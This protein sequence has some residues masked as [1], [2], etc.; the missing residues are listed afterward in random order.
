MVINKEALRY[1][2]V[3]ARYPWYRIAAK[4]YTIFRDCVASRVLEI[5]KSGKSRRE[6][7]LEPNS[8]I[9]QAQ[10]TFKHSKK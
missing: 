1:P 4:V 10:V 6:K 3:T 2:S 7:L 8:Q 9:A 5:R